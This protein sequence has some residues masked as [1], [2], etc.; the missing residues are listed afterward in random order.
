MDIMGMARFLATPHTTGNLKH[1][2]Y[3]QESS[4]E[5]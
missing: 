4:N 2:Y 3:N 5:V 1:A